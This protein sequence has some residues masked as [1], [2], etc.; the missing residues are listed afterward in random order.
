MPRRGSKAGEAV[1]RIAQWLK[2]VTAPA[3]PPS[4]V[5]Y[6]IHFTNGD[7]TEHKGEPRARPSMT[8][9]GVLTFYVTVDTLGSVRET[10]CFRG[11]R[12]YEQVRP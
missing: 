6:T 11:V 12:W 3:P 9:D 10:A 7:V 5:T 2:R 4:P 1:N 8:G